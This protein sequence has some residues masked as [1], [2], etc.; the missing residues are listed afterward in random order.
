MFLGLI[1]R[2]TR[3]G[4]RVIGLSPHRLL[5]DDGGQAEITVEPIVT[6]CGYRC[7]LCLAFERNVSEDPGNRETL[8]DGWS[9][10]YGFRIPP[11]EICCDGC[12][13]ED[14]VLI[15]D[16]CPVRPCVIERGLDNCSQ[17][18]SYPCARLEERTV[19]VEEIRER[20]GEDIPV[21]DYQR[22]IRPYENRRRLDVLRGYDPGRA[23][24]AA[25]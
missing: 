22:F 1:S 9:R 23:T 13:T 8:S 7:D 2:R 3:L 15:D 20:V 21:E 10:C 6:R 12:L 19:T 5:L 25:E 24:E 17:C 4:L 11:P 16:G 14:A 18:E